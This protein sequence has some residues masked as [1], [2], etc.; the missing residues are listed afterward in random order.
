MTDSNGT[1]TDTE[2]RPGSG[3]GSELIF[4][5]NGKKEGG[6]CRGRGRDNGCCMSNGSRA[7]DDV[8]EASPLFN[9][10][11]FAPFDP[12]QELIF[13]PELV[14]LTKGQRSGSLRF[15]GD[16]VVWL[17]PDSLDEFLRL[18]WENP[19]ARVV[20]GNTEV[21]IE[22]KF[23]NMVYPVILA[24]A[25]IPELN[26]VTHTE[27]GVVFGAACTLSHMGAVLKQAVETL[28]RHQTEVF[29]AVLEQ[30]R[31]FAGLQIRNVAVSCLGGVGERSIFANTQSE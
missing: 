28:P 26:A 20:V 30:L 8:T 9:A 5:V 16:R 19:D 22:V 21:G 15:H 25:F 12:T 18:K 7:E 3:T 13:P 31:W 2:T 1:M 6:C 14:S 23:K 11:D 10:A 29:L 4:F 27:H 17:Q 24:P